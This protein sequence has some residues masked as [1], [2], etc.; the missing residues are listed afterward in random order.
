MGAGGDES[1]EVSGSPPS[2]EQ[3]SKKQNSIRGKG[4]VHHRNLARVQRHPAEMHAWSKG[5]TLAL[6]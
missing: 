5:Q 4:G 2:S 3:S 6:G 1:R